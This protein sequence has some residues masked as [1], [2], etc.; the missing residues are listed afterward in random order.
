MTEREEGMPIELLNQLLRLDR[1]AGQLFWKARKP[2][3]FRSGKR[4]AEHVCANWNSR[5]AGTPALSSVDGSGHLTGRIFDK[6]FY[7]HRVIFAIENGRWP[8]G[9]IDHISGDPSD[10]RPENLRD[11]THQEN[12]RNQ[13]LRKNNTSG[14]LGVNFHKARNKWQASITVNY[15]AI[16]LGFFLTREEAIKARKDAQKR[17]GFHSNHG[18]V[19]S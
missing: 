15:R 5:Y 17:Y 8:E 4:P 9:F 1:E 7:A 11:V 3:L 12:H 14:S 10:N 2:S 6:L 19:A 13:R 16:H 18:G